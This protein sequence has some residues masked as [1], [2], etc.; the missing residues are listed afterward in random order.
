MEWL[1]ERIVRAR[2]ELGRTRRQQGPGVTMEC[3]VPELVLTFFLYGWLGVGICE[4]I[5]MIV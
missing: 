1:Q 2:K 3:N 4:S 5:L